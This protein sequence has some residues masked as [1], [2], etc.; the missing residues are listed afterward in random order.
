MKST[1]AAIVLAAM[2]ASAAHAQPGDRVSLGAGIG[3]HN[4]RDAAFPSKN[5]SIVP[6]YHFGLFSNGNRQGL[7]FGLKGGITYAQPGRND[8]IGGLETKT[9]DLRMVS[10]M[11]GAGPT[12]RT[13]PLSFGMAIL[14]GPSFNSFSVDDGASAA[15]RDREDATLN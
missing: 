4:Y 15:Y 2:I 3:F 12:Y 10:A 7:S 13:G 6:E 1:F 5:P 11:V 9:G 14:A 8:L